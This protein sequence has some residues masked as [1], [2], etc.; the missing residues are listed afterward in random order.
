MKQRV[1]LALMMPFLFIKGFAQ[2]VNSTVPSETSEDENTAYWVSP[3]TNN[4]R[5]LNPNKFRDNWFITVN[6]G[7]FLNWCDNTSDSKGK[8]LQP[9]AGLSVGK[10]LSPWGGFRVMGMWGRGF[11]Q[12][13]KPVSYTHLTLPTKA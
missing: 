4:E 6:A 5:V 1:F 3:E 2:E 8:Q 9:A 7:T 13:Y 12:T 10:W 11:G